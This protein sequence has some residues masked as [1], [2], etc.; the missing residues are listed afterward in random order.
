MGTAGFGAELEHRR[1]IL[2]GGFK[3]DGLGNEDGLE[4]DGLVDADVVTEDSVSDE[5]ETADA[6]AG[7]VAGG[8]AAV[9]TGGVSCVSLILYFHFI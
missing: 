1:P 3:P 9:S 6:A 8:G 4:S 5:E 2:E 7:G